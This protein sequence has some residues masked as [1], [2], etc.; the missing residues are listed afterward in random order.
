MRPLRPLL[1]VATV[2]LAVCILSAFAV[3][4]SDEAIAER[5]LGTRWKYLA[6]RAG[7][8]FAGTVLSA[9]ETRTTITGTVERTLPVIELAF[10]VD[11]P[12]AG[13]AQGQIIRIH[14]WT[15]ALSMH[16]PMRRGQRLLIFLYPPSRLGLTSPVDG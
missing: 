8:I 3:A 7:M 5:V 1:F 14:E 13:V 12:I 15:G 9:P 4:Q 6:S 2:C 11:R 16:R 10:H